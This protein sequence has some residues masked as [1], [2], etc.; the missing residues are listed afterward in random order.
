MLILQQE[1]SSWGE[2][3]KAMEELSGEK[4]TKGLH[5]CHKR[6][7]DAIT[8]VS[9]THHDA[10]KTAL[11]ETDAQGSRQE[12]LGGDIRK[13][14]SYYWREVR[15]WYVGEGDEAFV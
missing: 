12:T 2:I 8:R 14:G 4:P 5:T 10:L 15:G 1:G 13:D 9:D 6:I 11:E 3:E 7:K